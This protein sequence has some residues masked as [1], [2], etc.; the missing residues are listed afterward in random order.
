MSVV[1]LP[2]AKNDVLPVHEA[3]NELNLIAVERG[4]KM[5][6]IH[7]AIV[8][9]KRAVAVLPNSKEL[10]NNL[11]TF[12]WKARIY[13]EALA[14]IDRAVK[15]DPS[16]FKAFY[17]RALILEDLGQYEEAEKCFA[18]SLQNCQ[19]DEKYNLNWCRAMM[20]LSRG[21]YE[22]GWEGYEDRI[23]FSRT[24]G[25]SNR[26]P[27]FPA[28]YWQGEDISGKKI[29]C[30]VEQGLGDTILFSRFLPWLKQQV[31]ESG[32]VFLCCQH[33][34][35]I[36][37]WEFYLAGM[38]EWVPEGA[39]IPECDFSVVIGSLPWH[40]R[41]TL[42]TLPKDPGLIRKRANMQMKIGPAEIPNP[43][44]PDP[45][46]VGIV[47]TGNPEQERN[48]DRSIP[49]KLMLP[50]AEHPNVWLYSLQAFHDRDAIAKLGANDIICD[51]GGHLEKRGLTVAATALL[52][53][54]LIVTCCTSI[55]HLCGALGVD[56]WV[57]LCKNPYWVWMHDRTDSPWY[58][59]I[60]LYRQQEPDNWKDVMRQ[61]RDDL[62]D[63]VDELKKGNQQEIS[64]G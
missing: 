5:Q 55:A 36:L 1:V 12:L 40:S 49:L 19:T 13:D 35:I 23:P 45:Y 18:I 27:I 9:A 30:C 8:E 59:S 41:C 22:N 4:K 32:R 38:I 63:R 60:K 54:D 24:P 16:F 29:F 11:G 56:A 47:W 61:V 52:Q 43:L 51:L 21:D 31:G 46:K 7:T 34:V 14:C 62:I 6:H 50:L 42:E 2:S 64:H 3:V 37:L 48:L 44:G 10:W 20:R 26:Y 33:E 17:N 28:P 57:V 58:P 39:P 53:M 15:L 25:A